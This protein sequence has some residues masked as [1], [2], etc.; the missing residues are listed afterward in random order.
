MQFWIYNAQRRQQCNSKSIVF[1]DLMICLNSQCNSGFTMLSGDS[2]AIQSQLFTD[3]MI[4]LQFLN[5]MQF[6]IY[7]AMQFLIYNAQQL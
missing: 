6:L 7:N 4:L 5:A 3:L 1:T 2:S